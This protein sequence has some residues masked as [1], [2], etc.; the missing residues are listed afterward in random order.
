MKFKKIIVVLQK[1]LLSAIFEYVT[2]SQVIC[3]Q[4]LTCVGPQKSVNLWPARG[5]KYLVTDNAI[6]TES[7][8]APSTILLKRA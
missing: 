7:D 6:Q 4:R 3:R 1:Y 5:W 2:G 8:D